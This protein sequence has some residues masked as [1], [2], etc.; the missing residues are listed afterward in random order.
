MIYLTPEVKAVVLRTQF[1]LMFSL[2]IYGEASSE[3]N[4]IETNRS[5]QENKNKKGSKLKKV[6]LDG[7]PLSAG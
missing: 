2:T 7:Y 6:G 3:S 1:F 4:F 5:K